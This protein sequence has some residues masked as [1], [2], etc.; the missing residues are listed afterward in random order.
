M[1]KYALPTREQFTHEP[2]PLSDICIL[3]QHN[4]LTIE[5][6]LLNGFQKFGA[7]KNNT[8]RYAFLKG[9]DLLP[10]HLKHIGQLVSATKIRQIQ[11]SGEGFKIN[12]L[13]AAVIGKL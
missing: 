3:N 4:Q 5:T 1:E 11:R 10:G 8:Y 12:D 6:T 9:L 13:M 2:L 7:L